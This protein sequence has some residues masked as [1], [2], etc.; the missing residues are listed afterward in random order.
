MVNGVIICYVAYG[1]RVDIYQQ[2]YFS[3]LS[4]LAF[5]HHSYNI[6]VVTD[7]PEYFKR[8]AKYISV[9]VL[10]ESE[11][12]SWP[13]LHDYHFRIKLKALEK[14]VDSVPNSDVIFFDSDTFHYSAPDTIISQV[15]N[16]CAVFH[17]NEGPIS[18][19]RYDP[20]WLQLK[21][22]TFSGITISKQTCMFNS[23][24][25]GLPASHAS[26]VLRKA[27]IVCDQMCDELKEKGVVEQL[28]ISVTAAIELEC[29]FADKQVLHYWGNKEQWNRIIESYMKDA[30]LKDYSISD[31]ISALA[32][33][34]SIEIP[35]YTR[36][37][38]NNQ[39]LKS[40]ADRMFPRVKEKYFL[41]PL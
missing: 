6:R 33:F 19:N 31:E 32:N 37:Q 14:V 16:G 8:L 9:T 2:I 41:P 25:I 40:W 23:G 7:R 12:T 24:V 22:K 11:I 27:I 5:G 29:H 4:L 15:K 1:A 21:N 36:K 17:C 30:F 10:T 18:R 35:I 39:R 3:I 26:D 20:F 13:G 34:N 38:M 28:A